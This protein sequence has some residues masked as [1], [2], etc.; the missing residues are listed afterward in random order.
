MLLSLRRDPSTRYAWSGLNM[1]ETIFDLETKTFFDETG[2]SDPADLG[3]SVVSLYFRNTE[4]GEGEIKSFWEQDFDTMWKY[5]RDADRL[6]GFNSKNFD[7]PALSPYS[8]PD[9]AKLNHFDILEKIRD[10]SGHRTSLNR[11]AKDTLN[12]TKSDNPANAI[13]YWNDHSPASLKKLQEYCEQDVI[14]TRDVY[15]FVL[16]NKY[17]KFTDYWNNPRQLD[18]DFSYPHPQEAPKIQT[19]LF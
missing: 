9:F 4:T 10:A 14:L 16:K 7:V 13:T 2:T 11:I 8:P 12:N 5:F 15:D 17:L 3:V 1:F 19:S 6:I 18:L